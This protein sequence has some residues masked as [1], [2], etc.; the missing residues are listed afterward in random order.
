MHR[1]KEKR[2][3]VVCGLLVQIEGKMKE[4]NGSARTK[5]TI[6]FIQYLLEYPSLAVQRWVTEAPGLWHGHAHLVHR[7]RY[8]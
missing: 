6:A 7:E 3:T 2:A 8:L 1:I 5:D 4:N